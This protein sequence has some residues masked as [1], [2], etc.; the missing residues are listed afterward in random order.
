MSMSSKYVSG[1][2]DHDA[3]VLLTTWYLSRD[4]SA[5]PPYPFELKQGHTVL[6]A[7]FFE[8]L[9]EEIAGGPMSARSQTGALQDDI[10]A[11]MRIVKE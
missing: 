2:F 1:I 3:Y 11:L 7:K 5:W 8:R 10:R 6:G 4:P 9:N